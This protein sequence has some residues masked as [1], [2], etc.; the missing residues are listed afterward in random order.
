MGLSI[1]TNPLELWKFGS[2]ERAARGTP[3]A[4]WGQVVNGAVF[5]ATSTLR[6][7]GTQVGYAV[8]AGRTLVVTRVLFHSNA[9]NGN[10]NFRYTDDDLGL[11]AAGP[12]TNPVY[13]DT[14]G[15][16]SWGPLVAGVADVIYDASVYFE[17]PAGKYIGVQY[18]VL[19]GWLRLFAFGHEV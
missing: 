17:I 6:R 2:H 11:D 3:I 5:A 16:G 10:L 9:N 4:L 7:S 18:T 14:R 19:T 13:L 1:I 15:A 8:T 12:G